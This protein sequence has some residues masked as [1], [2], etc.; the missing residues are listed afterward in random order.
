MMN[1][2]NKIYDVI[3]VGAG[4]AGGMCAYELSK[5]SLSVLILEKEKLPRYKVCAGGLTT[6]AVEIISEDFQDLTE[7][8]TYNIHLTLNHK[9]GFSKI[10]PFPIVTMVMRDMFDL[11]LVQKSVE[12]GSYL[13]DQT[14]VSEINELADYTVAK[15]DRGNFVSKVIVGGDGVNSI[16]ARSL[17][18]RNKRRL[19]I[20][21]EGEIFPNNLSAD[22]S[23]YNGSLHLDFNVIPKGYGWIF[24]K[25][26]HLSVGVFTT[27]PKIKD[28]KEYFSLY[29]ERKSL[30]NNYTCS[31]L[32]G[33][34]IP[35][36][37]SYEKLNTKRGLLIGDAAGL[38]DP[39]TGEGIYYGLRSGQIAAEAIYR[40][41]TADSLSLNK[42]SSEV[43]SEII[44]ELKYASYIAALF[45]NLPLITYNLA[46]KI[47]KFSEA[48]VSIIKGE[49]S[50]KDIFTKMPKYLGRLLYLIKNIGRCY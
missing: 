15:T 31:S 39:I 49:T 30:S 11:F 7:N 40:S 29:L 16:V 37:G 2:P 17:G 5:R 25:R 34:Q 14:K 4:P 27:L 38:A 47:N 18:L 13:I 28:I 21:I 33:H 20:A 35:L 10:T 42:Y 50:Y 36:G 26:N 24:P 8:Y 3:I 1:N 41:L 22:I 45:Y 19:G 6:K 23:S 44:T 32:I 12:K 46:R 9:W 48:Y 43:A